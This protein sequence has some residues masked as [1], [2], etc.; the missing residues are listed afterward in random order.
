MSSVVTTNNLYRKLN[1]QKIFNSVINL[2]YRYL[3]K[4]ASDGNTYTTRGQ[5]PYYLRLDTVSCTSIS[6]SIYTSG[7]LTDFKLEF[8]NPINN[9]EVFMSIESVIELGVL[10][11]YKVILN[12]I[13]SSGNAYNTTTLVEPTQ[14]PQLI[15]IIKV[16][17]NEL[18]K[19]GNSNI[20]SL[21]SRNI[22]GCLVK[23]NGG[24]SWTSSINN[25][26]S[27]SSKAN[28]AT[29]HI[30]SDDQLVTVKLLKTLG[31]IT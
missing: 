9:T 29:T 13:N 16:G 5:S 22:S 25:L 6:L 27:S 1:T 17:N 4:N 7:T 3:D 31:I 19:I 10:K 12:N 24:G 28:V 26:L 23:F 2:K 20:Y 18:I 8:L 14:N 11:Y 30:T 21:G 15:S